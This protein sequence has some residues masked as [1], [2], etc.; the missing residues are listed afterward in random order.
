V[1]ITD[2]PMESSSY[3]SKLDYIPL[4]VNPSSQIVRPLSYSYANDQRVYSAHWTWI[5][6]TFNSNTCAY[7]ITPVISSC[8]EIGNQHWT[9]LV[10][11]KTSPTGVEQYTP[12]T[13]MPPCPG[14]ELMIARQQ[15]HLWN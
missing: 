14:E 15:H 4:N 9:A 3:I 8:L 7:G 13:S 5:S 6:N 11:S 2:T 12:S 1:L 10:S